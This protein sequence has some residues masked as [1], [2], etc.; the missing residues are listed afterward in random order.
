MPND[1][2]TIQNYLKCLRNLGIDAEI[3]TDKAIKE[4]PTLSDTWEYSDSYVRDG[5]FSGYRRKS[6]LYGYV[7]LYGYIEIQRSPIRWVEI[8]YDPGTDFSGAEVGD[9]DSFECFVPDSRSLPSDVSIEIK[10]IRQGFFHRRIKE[11]KWVSNGDKE[12]KQLSIKLA[13]I[14]TGDLE[15][16]AIL[17]YPDWMPQPNLEYFDFV[18][19]APSLSCWRMDGIEHVTRAYWDTRERISNLLLTTDF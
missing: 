9:N 19:S 17:D 5:A 14:L 1:N 12:G 16:K 15:L 8:S 2:T 13:E 4:I 10:Y 6:W 7:D 18:A 11:K 3:A